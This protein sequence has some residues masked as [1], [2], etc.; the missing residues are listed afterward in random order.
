MIHS[1]SQ[2]PG[3]F[4]P[5]RLDRRRATG[6]GRQRWVEQGVAHEAQ[7]QVASPHPIKTYLYITMHRYRGKTESSSNRTVCA[8][9]YQPITVESKHFSSLNKIREVYRKTFQKKADEPIDRYSEFYVGLQ[10]STMWTSR[11]RPLPPL[12]LM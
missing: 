5:Q 12:V 2:R 1:C 10:F 7:R 3:M 4:S 6:V 11:C 9:A 8:R